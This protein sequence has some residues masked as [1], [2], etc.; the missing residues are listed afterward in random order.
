VVS[1]APVNP[2]CNGGTATV[3]ASINPV[4]TATYAWTAAPGDAS[5][6]STSTQSFTASPISNT[7]YTVL[8]TDAKTCSNKASVIV[9]VN[10]PVINV[11]L[12]PPIC[13]GDTAEL[14]AYGASNYSWTPTATFKLSDGSVVF[15]AP[16]HKTTYTVTGTFPGCINTA[17]KDITV[18]VNPKPIVSATDKGY[19]PGGAATL[20][21][22]GNATN[23][24]WAPAL[25]LSST[26]GATVTANPAM[27]AIYTL[28]GYSAFNCFTSA[29]VKVTVYPVPTITIAPVNPICS[30][31]TTGL[32]A[33]SNDAIDFKWTP[34]P[35]DPGMSS[36]TGDNI[37]VGPLVNT[38]YTVIA[39]NANS[40]SNSAFQSVSV[41]D[42]V[43]NVVPHGPICIGDTAQ[44]KANGADSYTWSSTATLNSTGGPLVI[45]TPVSSGT[46]SYKIDALYK[47]CPISKNLSLMVN[48][49]PVINIVNP[50]QTCIG[51]PV[52]ITAS[53]ALTYVWAA[54][55]SLNSTVLSTVQANPL[56][57]KTYTYSVT[58]T[59]IN[60]CVNSKQ[61]T[62]IANGLP[63]P[64]INPPGTICLGG[65]VPLLVSNASLPAIPTQYNWD[66]SPDL[67]TTK[68]ASV[69]AKPS[70][71]N[72]TY[73]VLAQDAN[74]C[75]KKTSVNVVAV[76]KITPQISDSVHICKGEHVK[77]TAGGGTS[78]HWKNIEAPDTS[79]I[80]VSP[81][82]T[83]QYEVIISNGLCVD[84]AR[85]SVY[86][87]NPIPSKVFI[88]NAF[89]PN[90]DGLNDK[91]LVYASGLVTNFKGALFNRWGEIIFEWSDIKVGWDGYYKGSLVQLD[92]YVYKIN[93]TMECATKEGESHIGTVTIVK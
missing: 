61:T 66:A 4:Q 50:P 21:A 47:G 1:I 3:T 62:L 9:Q 54:E 39:T 40:C 58:G 14:R 82:V 15:D 51:T 71:L 16:T 80:K 52:S 89:T 91:F 35:A 44:L 23:F 74:N 79:S 57:P 92:V 41:I 77:L 87:K 27:S 72:T 36:T 6:S 10:S 90:E 63:A 24:N 37:V 56:I 28:T 32:V 53:G 11:K 70:G 69:I 29:P 46:N 81:V 78:Y 31:K 49:K 59:D 26:S 19:C 7:T 88:P 25:G 68:G 20:V 2:I 13:E 83:T 42:P 48:S 12:H 60:G 30:G 64:V 93:V 85:V 67:N 55:T 84:S 17:S 75:K 76:N 22:T 65:K 5:M 73:S 33:K 38:S 43:L 8:V 34:S 45:S 86:V 18:D